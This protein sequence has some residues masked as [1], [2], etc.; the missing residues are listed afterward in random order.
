MGLFL[1]KK[2]KIMGG[3]ALNQPTQLFSFSFSLIGEEEIML[4]E[5]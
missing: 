3:F 2:K 4:A 1:P 5:K